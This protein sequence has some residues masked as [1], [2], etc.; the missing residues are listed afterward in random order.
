MVDKQTEKNIMNLP[1]NNQR[2]STSGG[3]GEKEEFV[4][5]KEKKQQL[6][7]MEIEMKKPQMEADAGLSLLADV[8]I[9][10]LFF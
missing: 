6:K 8:M 7:K 2:W 9:V 10:G 5:R 3:V 4:N 1:I